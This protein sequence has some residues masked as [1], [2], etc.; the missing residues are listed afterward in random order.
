VRNC[1]YRRPH[2][3]K[4]VYRYF[5]FRPASIE[6]PASIRSF[7]VTVP[8]RLSDVSLCVKA[9]T[10]REQWRELRSWC[11]LLDDVL[12]TAYA[13]ALCTQHAPLLLLLLLLANCVIRQSPAVSVACTHHG[14]RPVVIVVV[15]MSN[16]AGGQ[17]MSSGRWIW[18]IA[19]KNRQ[20]Y[21]PSYN[22]LLRFVTWGARSGVTCT[23]VMSF[24]RKYKTDK[25]ISVEFD[26]HIKGRPIWD[27]FL[28]RVL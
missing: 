19:V 4:H 11:D 5:F 12:C 6:D 8:S 14:R 15:M 7:T 13:A 2:T 1:N 23:A 27:Q 20:H 18:L 3:T 21:I 17:Q 10:S 16:S 25:E 26:S 28:S 9:M 22:L 24:E